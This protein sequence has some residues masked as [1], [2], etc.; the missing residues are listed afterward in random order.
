MSDFRKRVTFIV[1]EVEAKAANFRKLEAEVEVLHAEAE[2]AIRLD[3]ELYFFF[4]YITIQNLILS[5]PAYICRSARSR[6]RS[7]QS[8]VCQQS[9]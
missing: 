9:V 4:V 8:A 2:G 5:T 1:V 3:V 6:S 7:Q